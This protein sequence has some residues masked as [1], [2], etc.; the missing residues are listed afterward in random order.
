LP[1]RVCETNSFKESVQ[2]MAL[3]HCWGSGDVCQLLSSNIDAYSREIPFDNLSRLFQDAI[4]FT[5]RAQ[6][7][8]IW[9]DALCIIQDSRKDWK[10]EASVMGLI[11]QNA[12]CNIAATGF[13]DGTNGLFASRNPSLLMP[14]RL[15]LGNDIMYGDGCGLVKMGKYLLIDVDALANGVDFA[16]LNKRAWV[17][18]ER[19]LSIRTIHFGSN[20][21]FWEC[22]TSKVCEVFPDG[23]LSGTSSHSPKSFL[24]F[25]IGDDGYP[26]DVPKLEMLPTSFEPKN[27]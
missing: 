3:S 14:I 24:R 26:G 4:K 27:V 15:N 20:Q 16:P 12:R 11:Y 13:A 5:A 9:I 7:N 17:A 10:N 21:L 8:Y 1:V 2:Y 18:Q 23:F 22:A 6:V 19:A 25:K